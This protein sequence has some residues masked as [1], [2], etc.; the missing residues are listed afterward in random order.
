MIGTFGLALFSHSDM[1]YCLFSRMKKCIVSL[2]GHD[3]FLGE[4]KKNYI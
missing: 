1:L 2:T 4:K 3:N